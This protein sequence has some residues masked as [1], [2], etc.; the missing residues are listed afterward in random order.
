MTDQQRLA[1]AR[2]L[3]ISLDKLSRSS[4]RVSPS[5]PWIIPAT[6]IVVTL[7]AFI[8]LVLKLLMNYLNSKQNKSDE[9]GMSE[10]SSPEIPT[11]PDDQAS[12]ATTASMKT[13]SSLRNSS[14][15]KRNKLPPVSLYQMKPKQSPS[16]TNSKSKTHRAAMKAI[17]RAAKAEANRSLSRDSTRQVEDNSDDNINI[18][19]DNS[20]TNLSHLS[21]D[22]DEVQALSGQSGMIYAAARGHVD[23]IDG[24]NATTSSNQPEVHIVQ[25]RD[26]EDQIQQL[27][28]TWPQ[29][30]SDI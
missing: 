19:G 18:D 3:S 5:A 17:S 20:P 15:R 23:E 21:D 12:M 30:E 7:F 22:T 24:L 13:R 27:Q 28:P 16:S 9:Y 26:L 8:C 2:A 4:R 1:E 10:T 6:M 29:T 25:I 11:T 14:R